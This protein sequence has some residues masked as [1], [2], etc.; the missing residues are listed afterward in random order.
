MLCL[1]FPGMDNRYV[2]SEVIATLLS[3]C[4]GESH[5]SLKQGAAF[6]LLSCGVLQRLTETELKHPRMNALAIAFVHAATSIN[7]FFDEKEKCKHLERDLQWEY[8][9]A[10]LKS[11]QLMRRVGD[12]NQLC[13]QLNQPDFSV[14]H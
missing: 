2:A 10:G 12:W 7:S 4:P 11:G 14:R 9:F 13:L 3:R 5:P 6:S 8:L 1:V